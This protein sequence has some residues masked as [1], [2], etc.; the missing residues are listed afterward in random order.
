PRGAAARGGSRGGGRGGAGPPQRR[1][2]GARG[3]SCNEAELME[4]GGP[5]RVEGEERGGRDWATPATPSRATARGFA[6][7]PGSSRAAV[8]LRGVVEEGGEAA[9]GPRGPG[10]RAD[11]EEEG[12][13]GVRGGVGVVGGEGGV[14]L[15]GGDALGPFVDEEAG[16]GALGERISGSEAGERH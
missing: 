9:G 1:V 10:V 15:G 7:S 6:S 14:L 5:P 12:G 11:R 8:A 3:T 2:G 13:G 4:A 16:V